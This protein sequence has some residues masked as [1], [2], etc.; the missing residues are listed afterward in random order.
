MKKYFI[1]YATT[2]NHY[3][4][5]QQKTAQSFV[6]FNEFDNIFLCT[7]KNIKP[8]YREQHKN[9]FDK[10][11]GTY[12]GIRGNFFI[13]KPYIIYRALFEK[14]DYGD[15]LF[16]ADCTIEQIKSLKPIIDILETQSFIPFLVGNLDNDERGQTKR[17]ALI[18]MDC[19]EEKYFKPCFL[20]NHVF[21]K[22]DETS[23][24]FVKDW[25]TYA[26][27]ERIITDMPNT[28]GVPDHELFLKMNGHRHDQSI[29]SCLV[30]K[31]L[32]KKPFKFY[33]DLTQYGNEDRLPSET[34]GQLLFHGR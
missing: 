3:Y 29:F 10:K 19:D 22:K 20:A 31:Y 32:H 23:L 28:L 27:D 1:S 25:L 26:E 4:P 30:K 18:L 24:N 14:L 5:F 15:I 13:W 6:N 8:Y 33:Q 11:E 17:D 16:Y 2:Y 34:W 7:E 9:I 12:Q 21:F